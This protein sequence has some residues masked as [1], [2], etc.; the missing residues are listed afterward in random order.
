MDDLLLIT[1]AQKV[2]NA[3]LEFLIIDRADQKIR[4]SGLERPVAIGAI[5]IDRYNNNRHIVAKRLRAKLS[6]ELGGVHTRR[7]EVRN[8][9][10]RRIFR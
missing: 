1:H 8:H 9:Q 2:A 6:R 3:C 5:L 4:H 10:I 7:L